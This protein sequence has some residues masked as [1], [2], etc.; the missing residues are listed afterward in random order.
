MDLIQIDLIERNKICIK[1]YSENPYYWQYKERPVLLVGASKDHN[2]FQIPDIEEHLD[3]I[4]QAGGNFVRNTMSD[5]KDKDFKVYPFKKLSDGKYDL[6]QWNEEFWKR[7][8]KFLKLTYEKDIIVQIEI[9]DR[10]DYSRENWTIHPYNP[11]NNI[12]YTSQESGLA[13]EYPDHPGSNK[14]PFFYTT[15]LQMN[16]KV[17]FYYQKK[18]VEEILKRTLVYPHVLYCMDNETSGD[19]KWSIFWATFV[20]EKAKEISAEIFI[21]E[22]W[23][24]RDLKHQQHRTT[25]DNPEIFDYV[26]ISQNN[27]QKG[28]VHWDNFQWVRSYLSEKP[29]PMN[30]VK[31]YGS[32]EGKFGN[33]KDGIERFWRL[34]VG[35]AAGARFHRPPSGLGF[36]QLSIASI[37]SVRKLETLLKMW[38]MEPANHLLINRKENSAYLSAKTGTWY[39]VYFTDGGS[40]EI[41]FN[42]IGGTFTI[43][44]INIRN[45]EWDKKEKIKA[46]TTVEIKAP[47]CGDWLAVIVKD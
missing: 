2:L 46:G 13:F 28:Q 27:H 43:H 39:L 33:S 1:P 10:F 26:E 32:D 23:D 5:R 3:E 35:G 25:F 19:P 40:V 24:S 6:N 44:W 31:I 14:Q 15:P 22:M 36:S 12:N 11:K 7:F 21:T 37:K 17:V 34:I 41:N 16:N 47:G 20:R 45:G 8:E 9:W 18:F 30:S 4:K 42:G 29:R 38:E